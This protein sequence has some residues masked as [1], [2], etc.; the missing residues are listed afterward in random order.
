MLG[1]EDPLFLSSFRLEIVFKDVEINLEGNNLTD[2]NFL[3]KEGL[4]WS[5]KTYYW[6]HQIVHCHLKGHFQFLYQFRHMFYQTNEVLL[7]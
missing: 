5:D 4:H 7:C 6:P 2:D 3:S 1:S